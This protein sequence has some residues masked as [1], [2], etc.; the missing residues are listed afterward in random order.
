MLRFYDVDIAYADFLRSF[1][2]KVPQIQYQ[3]NN[4]FVCGIVFAVDGRNYFAP[5]S[6]HAPKQKTSQ[7]I[8]D[9]NG[10]VLSSIKFSFM[11]PAPTSVLTQKDFSAI[12]STDAAYADLLEKEYEFCTKHEDRLRKKAQSAYR[13][14]TNPEHV[15]HQ[16]C[17]DF[18]LLEAKHDEWIAT[19]QD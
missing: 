14:G 19:H 8:T 6:S 13:I 17:C 10:H 15:L 4:K 16:Y 9:A 7:L 12:R 5:I 18:K 11:F 2:P 3:N 1:E